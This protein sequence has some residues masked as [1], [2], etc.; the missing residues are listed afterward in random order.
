MHIPIKTLTLQNPVH[1]HFNYS[2]GQFNV[3]R[4]IFSD[5]YPRFPDVL[6]LKVY[7]Y[8][9]KAEGGKFKKVT[10]AKSVI[11]KNLHLK[12]TEL[13][14]ALLWLES[15]FFIKRTNTNNKQMYQ[16]KI[17]TAPDYCPANNVFISCEE[18]ST[19]TK[20]FKMRNQ[21]YIMIPS[22]A[23]TNEMLK[24]TASSRRKWT[25]SKLS[26]FLMLYA[27]CWLDYFGGVNP[28]VIEL[29]TNH[30]ITRIEPS[31]HFALKESEKKIINIVEELM[32]MQ[33]VKAVPV[34]FQQGVYI[35]DQAKKS[36]R[37]DY[38]QNI[39]LRPFHLSLKKMNSI[40]VD[41]RRFMIL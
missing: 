41:K 17:L 23:V 32:N 26:V 19:H 33:L 31:F 15:N 29:D 35:G 2:N 4:K 22:D 40:M 34:Y 1:F 28:E 14:N 20:T 5:I 21:G 36:F 37:K 25:F 30:N 6:T 24:N 38:K 27:H 8:L 9:C 16:A 3:Q 12:R 13:N 18:I 11:Q 39:V 10:T 7:I